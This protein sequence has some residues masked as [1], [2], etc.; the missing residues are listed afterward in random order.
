MLYLATALRIYARL[1]QTTQGFMRISLSN[2]AIHL[3]ASGS[4]DTPIG[5]CG[6]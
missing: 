3:V 2:E 4:V 1:H 6:S 5:N